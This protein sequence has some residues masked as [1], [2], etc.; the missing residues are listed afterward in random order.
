MTE[1][2]SLD[3]IRTKAR[4][5]VGDS[6]FLDA[7]RTDNVEHMNAWIEYTEIRTQ[8]DY[9]DVPT[10]YFA[11]RDQNGR[12]PI[13][14]ATLANSTKVLELML[15]YQKEYSAIDA[16]D[17]QGNS[18]LHMAF[19]NKHYEA[20][21]LLVKHGA[22]KHAKNNAGK[23]PGDFIECSPAAASALGIEQSA[24][25]DSNT[26]NFYDQ[27]AKDYLIVAIVGITSFILARQ[28]GKRIYLMHMEGSS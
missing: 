12:T 13:M 17:N 23:L 11:Q 4:D 27:K 14:L 21:D 3:S 1:V 5:I 28:F 8:L 19:Q 16:C 15:S 6:S 9:G 7:I 10:R 26:H 25:A 2:L 22:N 18:A 24:H 20:A